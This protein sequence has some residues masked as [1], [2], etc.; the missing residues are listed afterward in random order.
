MNLRGVQDCSQGS[1]YTYISRLTG[2][3]EACP[4][5]PGCEEHD[6]YREQPGHRKEVQF[7]D[8]FGAADA[9]DGIEWA[10][11]RKQ[12]SRELNDCCTPKGRTMSKL[13]MGLMA[14]A[15][16]LCGGLIAIPALASAPAGD[17]PGA[18]N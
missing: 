14:F 7:W 5:R 8:C 1:E 13:T 10:K 12:R 2:Q 6:T 11:T 16:L 9:P 4:S 3:D 17:Q 15:S 18:M